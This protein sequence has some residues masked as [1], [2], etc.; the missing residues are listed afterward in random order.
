[1]NEHCPRLLLLL[2][3]S[4]AWLPAAGWADDC[5][6]LVATGNPEY[7][8]Y[9]WRDPHDPTQLMGA[10][11]DLL[12]QVAKELGLVVE[13]VYAGPWS[14]AQEEAR[15]GRI[16]ML[17]GYFLTDARQQAM[18]FIKPAFLFTPS[19]VWVRADDTFAY[20][21]WADLHGRNGGTLV[22]NSHG[23]K[24]DDYAKAHLNLEAVPTA[25]Q[26]F[27]KLLHKRND[28]VIYEQFPGVALAQTLGVQHNLKVLEP[29]VSSEGLY[30]ALSREAPCI[31]PT[32]REALERKMREV[33]A[34]DL[35][36]RL[37]QENL[38]RWK[39][40]QQ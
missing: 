32:L 23:Q 38:E 27:Q 18:D 21:G 12:K 20:T 19:V 10:N 40:Q 7:P 16:D 28:Y 39:A 14:R 15:T 36:E 29:P 37:V 26:A 8:P 6:H 9:L 34:S 35:P 17:A 25:A 1:M 5:K 2:S 30:L 24:F 31:T 33:V 3:L 4:L 22:S 13:V 11:A